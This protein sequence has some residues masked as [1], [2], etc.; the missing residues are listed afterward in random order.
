MV[1]DALMPQR[2]LEWVRL[3]VAYLLVVGTTSERQGFAS[4]EKAATEVF[5]EVVEEVA[6]GTKMLGGVGGKLPGVEGISLLG[7]GT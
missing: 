1:V 5:W 4:D 2:G 6:R 3:T 7:R